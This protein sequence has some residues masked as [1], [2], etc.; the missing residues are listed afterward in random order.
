[1]FPLFVINA[2]GEGCGWERG[3]GNGLDL[4]VLLSRSTRGFLNKGSSLLV[5]RGLNEPGGEKGDFWLVL[6][7]IEPN[8]VMEFGFVLLCRSYLRGKDI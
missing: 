5:W 8:F 7:V 2:R 1:M 3:R 6:Y 4:P